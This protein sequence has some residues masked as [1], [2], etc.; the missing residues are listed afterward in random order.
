MSDK[1]TSVS[2]LKAKLFF[3]PN[4]G[5]IQDCVIS[6]EILNLR[7]TNTQQGNLKQILRENDLFHE[8]VFLCFQAFFVSHLQARIL[9]Y[10]PQDFRAISVVCN[11]RASSSVALYEFIQRNGLSET[12]PEFSF[13][14]CLP[15]LYELVGIAWVAVPQK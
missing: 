6:A 15:D 3:A 4:T 8:S 1:L 7:K 2:K 13:T 14:A 9:K 5:K 10:I 11:D 12:M